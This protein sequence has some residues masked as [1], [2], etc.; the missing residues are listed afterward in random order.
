MSICQFWCCCRNEDDES[1]NDSDNDSYMG[2]QQVDWH[3]IRREEFLSNVLRTQIV[4]D[5]PSLQCED[6]VGLQD[7][8]DKVC[9]ICLLDYEPGDTL[10]TSHN[11]MCSHAFHRICILEWLRGND[12]CPCCRQNYLEFVDAEECEG[13]APQPTTTTRASSSETTP[14]ERRPSVSRHDRPRRR[15][16]T[17]SSVSQGP[18]TDASNDAISSDDEQGIHW[19]SSSSEEEDLF[20]D[21]GYYG[22]RSLDD[23]SSD[24]PWDTILGNTV[25]RIR[26]QV[27]PRVQRAREA[28]RD[29]RN[30]PENI[31][32]LERSME[33]VRNR[34]TRAREVTLR[35]IRHRIQQQQRNNNRP[36]VVGRD[37]AG[38]RG[39][40]R[41]TSAVQ[42]VR[43]RLHEVANARSEDSSMDEAD[44][45]TGSTRR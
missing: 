8:P 44:L 1:I 13:V 43:A 14:G 27:G 3:Q 15:D 38:T 12:A 41:W 35:E 23:S 26:N 18:S 33:V 25:G 28:I 42:L 21:A 5:D 30:N 31:E 6:I 22:E 11:A 17:P 37:G 10:V 34:V 4:S 19:E 24:I 29:Y 32:R 9:A 39:R 36:A 20:M 40:Q 7:L 45:A 16:V 2:E